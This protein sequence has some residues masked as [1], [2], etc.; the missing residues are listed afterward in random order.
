MY[1]ITL[2]KI[3]STH[4]NLRTDVVNGVAPE[5]PVVGQRFFMYSDEVLTEATNVRHIYTSVIASVDN[6]GDDIIFKTENSLYMLSNIKRAV[7]AQN[8]KP[9]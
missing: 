6:Q 3:E 7:S 2:N 9:V 1:Y 8:N 5:L 4:K